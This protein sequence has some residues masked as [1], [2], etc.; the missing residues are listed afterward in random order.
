[1]GEE[2]L[3]YIFMSMNR[4]RRRHSV[5]EARR[6]LPA[7]IRAAEG[8]STVEISRRGEPVAVLV[9]RQRFEDLSGGR[10]DFMEA[11]REFLRKTDLEALDLDPDEI[12]ADVRDR[13]PGRDVEL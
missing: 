1:M 3:M 2:T 7:L 12:F 10:P 6:H 4:E 13:S 9:S 11:Y 5:A 8:G